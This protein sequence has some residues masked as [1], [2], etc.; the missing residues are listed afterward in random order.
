[1]RH[2]GHLEDGLIARQRNVAGRR[3]GAA[4]AER[5]TCTTATIG[6]LALRM[7]P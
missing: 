6:I 3:D 7:A 2:L 4:E 5:A 1:V